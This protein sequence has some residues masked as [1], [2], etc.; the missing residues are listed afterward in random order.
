MKK[1]SQSC[2]G[3]L[4]TDSEEDSLTSSDLDKDNDDMPLYKKGTTTQLDAITDLDSVYERD[5][6]E[7][8]Y[9]KQSIKK[10]QLKLLKP[11]GISV[12]SCKENDS[13]LNTPI[14][15]NNET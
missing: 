7:E 1:G 2:F 13:P 8:F 15:N 4:Y 12:S 14:S 9:L 10:D 5:S 6:D 3:D 11:L